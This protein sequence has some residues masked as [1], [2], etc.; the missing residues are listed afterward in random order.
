MSR[1]D[2]QLWQPYVL[3]GVV[4][5]LGMGTAYVPCNTTVVKWFARRRGLAVG[6]ASRGGSLG[7]FVLPP[8]AHLAREPARLAR[9]LRRLR[10]RGLRS[11]STRVATVMRRDPESMGLHPDGDARPAAR[12]AG[13]PAGW[14]LGAARC[15]PARSGCWSPC[16]PRPGSRSSSRSCTWCRS[17]AISASRRSLAATLVSAL[18][19]AALVG[20]ARHGRRVGPDRPP[21]HARASGMAL[22]VVAFVGARARPTALPALYAAALALRLLLRR[23]SPTLFPAIG[24][25]LLRARARRQPRRAA[26]RAGRLDGRLGPAGG[27]LHLRPPP[28]A[29]E[30]AWWL[31]AGFNLRSPLALLAALP[32]ARARDP[33]ARSARPEP[34]RSTPAERSTAAEERRWP[35]KDKYCIVGVGET[36]YSRESGRTHPRDGGGG[37]P[38]GHP[39]RR[40]QG[41]RRGRHDELPERRL[42]A[43]A[44]A[45]RPTSASASTST[46]T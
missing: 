26:L 6:L 45:W 22:Q 38:Q 31:G 1:R 42:H 32:A 13:A 39:R 25:G 44:A 29:T 17:R 9:R 35:L 40:A 37:D 4:A 16:S 15:A 14:T 24:R 5:A 3:Y 8:V 30:L 27:G 21:A 28:A 34:P 33:L 43:R 12:R 7:T 11:C 20:P 23:R 18:G 2:A 46:W 41:Q 19:A 36:E 10:R